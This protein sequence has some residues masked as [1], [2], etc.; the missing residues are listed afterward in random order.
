MFTLARLRS[1]GSHITHIIDSVV[2]ISITEY[3]IR[4]VWA[5]L[6]LGRT[7]KVSEEKVG[8]GFIFQYLS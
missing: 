5:F 8:P 7:W 1:P 2:I 6:R 4:F 3:E